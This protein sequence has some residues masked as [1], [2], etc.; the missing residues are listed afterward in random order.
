ME[1]KID[2]QIAALTS[3]VEPDIRLVRHMESVLYDKEWFKGADPETPVYYMYRGLDKQGD[4]RYDITIIPPLMLGSE[5]NKTLGHYHE[6]GYGEL[7]TVLEG[8][9]TYLMQKKKKTYENISDAYYVKAQ[10][11]DC[12]VVPPL[13]AHFTI[14]ETENPLVM[15]NWVSE[16]FRSDYVPVKKLGGACYFRTGDGWIMN[17]NYAEVPVLRKVMP[18]E[19]MPYNLNFLNQG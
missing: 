12:I 11:G 13:Y 16:K 7:Y 5:F 15:A 9:G 18:E 14:N 4:L 10:K 1:M 19:K 17:R 8:E 6:G 3:K 2:P